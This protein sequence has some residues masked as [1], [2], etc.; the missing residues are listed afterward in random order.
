MSVVK[1]CPQHKCVIIPVKMM[2]IFSRRMWKVIFIS[3]S[4]LWAPL[5][6]SLNR[7]NP[8]WTASKTWLHQNIQSWYRT[9]IQ[10]AFQSTYYSKS[11]HLDCPKIWQPIVLNCCRSMTTHVLICS[12]NPSRD[13][14]LRELRKTFA[15][16]EDQRIGV[17]EHWDLQG[18]PGRIPS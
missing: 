8:N 4:N 3:K 5:R 10:S 13:T 12:A 9:H 2:T 7:L 18:R 17:A 11:E 1:F 16:S 14:S 15:F 6:Q